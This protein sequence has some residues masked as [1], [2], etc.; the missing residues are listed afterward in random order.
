[1][2][3]S[4]ELVEQ[5]ELEKQEACVRIKQ[6]LEELL[7]V[8]ERNRIIQTDHQDQLLNLSLKLKLESDA[9]I[10]DLTKTINEQVR[11]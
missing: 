3:K 8:K 9:T 2:K 10:N 11:F 6:L 5:V 4:C 7:N 1:M